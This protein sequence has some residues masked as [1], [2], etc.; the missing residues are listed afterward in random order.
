MKGQLILIH[1]LSGVAICGSYRDN[2]D[3]DKLEFDFENHRSG[4]VEK[5]KLAEIDELVT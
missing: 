5:V 3:A 1:L 4:E 2:Y